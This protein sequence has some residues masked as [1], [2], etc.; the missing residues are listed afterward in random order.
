MTCARCRRASAA[1]PACR[2]RRDPGDGKAIGCSAAHQLRPPNSPPSAAATGRSRPSR[3]T[4][5]VASVSMRMW[6]TH[7]SSCSSVGHARHVGGDERVEQRAAAE[8]EAVLGDGDLLV[9]RR[10]AQLAH[11]LAR[12]LGE[13]D[14]RVV[15]DGEVVRVEHEEVEGVVVHL[16]ISARSTD[17][18]WRGSSSR[19]RRRRR[20]SRRRCRRTAKSPA[21]R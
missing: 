6:R 13:A 8:E 11:R 3:R 7:M 16:T 1:P 14:A 21:R 5:R 10:R 12:A 9:R 20:P 17:R 15:V 2:R 18:R 19:R 4:A